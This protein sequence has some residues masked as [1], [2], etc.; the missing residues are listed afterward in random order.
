[1][2][3]EVN[4]IKDN[5]LKSIEMGQVKMKP[6]WHF[7]LS[8]ILLFVGVV[9]A[10]LVLVYIISFIIFVLH[11]TGA[12][13]VPGFGLH[14]WQEFL[15]SFPWL[16]VLLAVLFI[17]ILEILVRKYSF[18]YRKPLLFTTV[19]VLVFVVGGGYVVAQTSFHRGLFD[20]S[21]EEHL[22]IAGG[23]YKQ[24]GKPHRDNVAIGAITEIE[25]DTGYKIQDRRNQVFEIMFDD[26]TVFPDGKSFNVGDSIVVFG[27]HNS[28]NVI[29][30]L[31]IKKVD[32]TEPPPPPHQDEFRP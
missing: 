26:D 15:M 21:I 5:I 24:Y 18:G 8:A 4:S 30:A 23:F 28:T 29:K 20:Q 16:I 25:D 14:G 17:V 11:Q 31:G 12:W 22:P 3:D 27:N 1:M 32:G 9:W 19:G 6:K 2:N 13:F 10:V 7:V